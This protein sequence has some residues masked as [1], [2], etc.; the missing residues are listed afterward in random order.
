MGFLVLE[1]VEFHSENWLL[2]RVKTLSNT[3]LSFAGWCYGATNDVG[4]LS[5]PLSFVLLSIMNNLNRNKTTLVILVHCSPQAVF[6]SWRLW[7]IS[8]HSWSSVLSSGYDWLSAS[9]DYFCFLKS[10][11]S[12]L[13]WKIPAGFIFKFLMFRCISPGD[14]SFS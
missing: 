3:L 1:L 2:F 5:L 12:F 10:A 6:K 7:S 8:M 4:T 13:G 9:T 11:D 14:L